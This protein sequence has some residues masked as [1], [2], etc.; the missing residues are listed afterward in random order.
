MEPLTKEAKVLVSALLPKSSTLI[1]RVRKS[2]REVPN[3][4][5]I[6]YAKT[7]IN[8]FRSQPLEL[9]HQLQILQ[10]Y[11]NLH[12][13]LLQHI[14]HQLSFRQRHSLKPLHLQA[15]PSIA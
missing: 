10:D 11:F 15:A 5:M 13:H 2:L 1:S 8:R 14:R 9:L 12:R 7:D 6:P 3:R 4:L